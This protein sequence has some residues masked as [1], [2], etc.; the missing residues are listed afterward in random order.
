MPNIVTTCTRAH[1]RVCVCVTIEIPG[2]ELFCL[3]IRQRASI[4]RMD[5]MLQEPEYI[6]FP[7]QYPQDQ[8]RY[9]GREEGTPKPIFIQQ[10]GWHIPR[11]AHRASVTI[12]LF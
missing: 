12:A 3:R 4:V 11:F 10:T 5:S 6:P 9:F 1:S 2:N 8:D 7:W